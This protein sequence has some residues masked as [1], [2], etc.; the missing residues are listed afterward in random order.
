M[1][2]KC[3]IAQILSTKRWKKSILFPATWHFCYNFCNCWQNKNG[4]ADYERLVLDKLI[5]NVGRIIQE[6]FPE[7]RKSFLFIYSF[8]WMAHFLLLNALL[9]RVLLPLKLS[10]YSDG[11]HRQNNIICIWA[12]LQIL[13]VF[14]LNDKVS[15]YSPQ[16]PNNLSVLSLLWLR[17]HSAQ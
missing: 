3:R 15:K 4:R 16:C 5:S 8:P 12:H 11:G 9:T 1:V 7:Q 10:Y 13:S 14:L 17:D 6:S 2:I